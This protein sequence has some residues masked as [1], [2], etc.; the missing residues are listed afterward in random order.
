MTMSSTADA[1]TRGDHGL[2]QLQTNGLGVEAHL[3]FIIDIPESDVRLDGHLG[4]TAKIV[5][6]FHNIGGFFH[7]RLGVLTLDQILGEVDV[8][9]AGVDLDGVRSHGRR[10]VHV[11]RKYF[12]VELHQLSGGIGMLFCIGNYDGNGVPILVNLIVT[13]N[14]AVPAVTLVGG[15]GYQ[16]GDA[17]FALDVLV[18]DNLDHAQRLLCRGGIDPL[19]VGMGHI[20]IR[21]GGVESAFGELAGLVVAEI[22]ETAD[23]GNG[24]GTRIACSVHSAVRR[25][26]VFKGGYGHLTAE[27]L[28]GV[29]NGVGDGDVTGAAAGIL[30]LVEPVTHFFTGR[31]RVGIEERLGGDD[32][33]RG[34]EAALECAVEDESLL[35]GVE[36]QRCADP[37]DGGNRC[38]VLDSFHPGDTGTDQLPI[39]NHVTRSACAGGAPYLYS[40]QM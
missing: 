17:V 37:L 11:V 39:H 27:N 6:A 25:S 21:E 7:D 4:L 5:L 23:L 31:V 14:R 19:D 18:G 29:H 20:G 24:C 2:V 32:K 33:A 10:C 8:R 34:A 38:P 13:E 9:G 28:G 16:T 22:P 12:Q 40:G 1:D 26:L 30:V 15:E 35:E 36:V 3:A